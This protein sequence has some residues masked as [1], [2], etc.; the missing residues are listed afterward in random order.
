[1]FITKAGVL[2]NELHELRESSDTGGETFKAGVDNAGKDFADASAAA[3][4]KFTK[5][6]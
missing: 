6:A 1:L 2:V 3:Q 5:A 4:D